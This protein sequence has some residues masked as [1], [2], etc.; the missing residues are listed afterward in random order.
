MCK[1]L[2]LNVAVFIFFISPICGQKVQP[3][4]ET[5]ASEAATRVSKQANQIERLVNALLREKFRLSL[6]DSVF[7]FA[8]LGKIWKDENPVTAKDF[9]KKAVD[10]ASPLL[11]DSPKERTEKINLLRKL[12]TLSAQIDSKIT[13][14]IINQLRSESE[15]QQK[16]SLQNSIAFSEASLA[17]ITT[18]PKLGF[19]LAVSALSLVEKPSQNEK[20]YDVILFLGL[21]DKKLSEELLLLTLKLAQNSSDFEAIG[22]LAL[23][24]SPK[25][26]TIEVNFLSDN[27]KRHVLSLFL[28]KL[29]QLSTL[30]QQNQILAEQ[31]EQACVFFLAG[32]GLKETINI[33]LPDKSGLLSQIT[34]QSNLCQHASDSSKTQS[35]FEEMVADKKDSTVEELVQAADGTTDITKKAFYFL[36][37]VGKLSREK[38]FEKAVDLLDAMDESARK[39]MGTDDSDVF[40]RAM[41]NGNALD[42][43]KQKLQAKDLGGA[44]RIIE[45][46]PSDL[47]PTL[48]I[49]ASRE[50]LEKVTK[51][52]FSNSEQ[53]FA[54]TL[55]ADARQK[56]PNTDDPFLSVNLYLS[57]LRRYAILLPDE[58]TIVFREAV[59]AINR[60]DAAKDEEKYKGKDFANGENIIPLPFLLLE[61]NED[62][63][64]NQIEDIAKPY[65]RVRL[66]LGLLSVSMARYT[67]IKMKLEEEK[68]R[69]K[70]SQNQNS[71]N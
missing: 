17:I 53:S 41:R 45:K 56:L 13:E 8:S 22:R 7:L 32:K 18:N 58:V 64:L 33:Y 25:S 15:A 70:L 52:D 40:W 27:S 68:S 67:E 43:I 30:S 16:Q 50:I 35:V 10:E 36:L 5:R 2:L 48:Q 29:V 46:T 55:I 9:F 42:A 21:K 51:V 44:R 38:K 4:P 54:F 3:L 59:K 6:A 20:I 63:V 19:E 61:N 39:A 71:L 49:Q 24:T 14:K 26:Y 1:F 31:K 66:K 28:D 69:K 11:T 65:S 47:R 62:N 37:A 60:A 12:L 23:F 34:Q 57:L